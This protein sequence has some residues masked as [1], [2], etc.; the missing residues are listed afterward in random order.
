M[1]KEEKAKQNPVCPFYWK[2]GVRC[3]LHPR[4]R[5]YPKCGSVPCSVESVP[6]VKVSRS[7][8]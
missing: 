2:E 1:M 6:D 3:V 8:D 7:Q 4:L 5:E